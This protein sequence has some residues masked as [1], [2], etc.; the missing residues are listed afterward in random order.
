MYKVPKVDNLKVEV[1]SVLE[2]VC[3]LAMAFIRELL[4]G[5]HIHTTSY[6]GGNIRRIECEDR[7]IIKDFIEKNQMHIRTSY[8]CTCEIE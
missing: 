1:E 7:V 2:G 5:A 6:L 3:K 4:F 8:M